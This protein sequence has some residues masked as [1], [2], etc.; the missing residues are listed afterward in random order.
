MAARRLEIGRITLCILMNVDGMLPGRQVL[1]IELELHTLPCRRY[2]H[3]SH[4]RALSILHRDNNG[5]T[6][7][8]CG[9]RNCEHTVQYR[10]K[11]EISFHSASPVRE[12]FYS[13]RGASVNCISPLSRELHYAG[14]AGPV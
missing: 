10:G 11:C 2:L 3:R 14:L 5:L 8:L 7:S 6:F 12:E 4:V 9:N 13:L 1:E